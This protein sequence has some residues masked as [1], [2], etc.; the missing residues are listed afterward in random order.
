MKWAECLSEY[1]LKIVYREGKK[2][3][4]DGLS[5]RPDYDLPNPNA[6]STAAEHTRRC[7]RDGS[8]VYEPV[9][10]A[11]ELQA[12]QLRSRMK[13]KTPEVEMSNESNMSNDTS[14]SS[15]ELQR[16][17]DDLDNPRLPQGAEGNTPQV[18][19]GRDPEEIEA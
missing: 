3:P 10:K 17:D 19:P 18:Q 2:N 12:M 7:F 6:T 15:T 13:A 14:T 4:A 5:R 8:N 9:Q 16:V 11:L 1:D